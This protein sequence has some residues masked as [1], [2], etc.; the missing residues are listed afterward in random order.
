MI[1]CYRIDVVWLPYGLGGHALKFF[2]WK[3][4]FTCMFPNAC[5]LYEIREVDWYI[6][7]LACTYTRRII[8][9]LILIS[10]LTNVYIR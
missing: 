1:D 8:N 10:W 7:L 6:R 2:L 4:R 5:H 3:Y 9:M